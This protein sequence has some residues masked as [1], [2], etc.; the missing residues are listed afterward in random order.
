[1]LL[2]A[3]TCLAPGTSFAGEQIDPFTHD[4]LEEKQEDEEGEE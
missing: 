1:M 4:V 2:V 3:M